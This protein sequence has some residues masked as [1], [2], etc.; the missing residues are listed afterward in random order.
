MPEKKAINVTLPVFVSDAGDGSAVVF[1]FKTLKDA[2]KAAEAELEAGNPS[3]TDNVFELDITVSED[4]ELLSGFEDI[5]EFVSERSEDDFLD[6][7]DDSDDESDD[8]EDSDSDSDD[9]IF[10]HSDDEEDPQEPDEEE[11]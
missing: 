7:D 6:D 5:D 1:V 2:E 4:G 3:F 10:M 9:D 11:M 8:D